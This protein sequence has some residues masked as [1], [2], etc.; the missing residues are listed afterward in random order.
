MKV[1]EDFNKPVSSF[2]TVE[3]DLERVANK[4]L[5]NPRLLKLLY[6]PEADCETR[7]NLTAEQKV[8]LINKQ[9]KVVP[10]IEIDKSCPIYIVISFEQFTPN[11]K[12]HL[13]RDS[14][15]KFQIL[16]HPDHWNLGNFR[17][18]PYRIAGELDAMFNNSKMVGIGELQFINAT[19]LTENEQ[20]EGLSLRYRSIY[21]T[22]DTIPNE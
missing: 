9:I 20:M 18:R 22:E 12:N 15:L 10:Y 1:G 21:S 13:F 4:I 2:L 14:V 11:Y 5:A 8:S 6:Y 16:C 7:P 17:L 19:R 3:K